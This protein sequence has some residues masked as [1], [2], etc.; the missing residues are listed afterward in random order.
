MQPAFW[1][2]FVGEK[3]SD[4]RWWV[5]T[6]GGRVLELEYPECEPHLMEESNGKVD[7]F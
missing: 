2:G 6:L 7:C 4:Q 5:S 1:G 3:G